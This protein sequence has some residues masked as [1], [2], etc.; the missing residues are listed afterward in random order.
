MRAFALFGT[1]A[2]LGITFGPTLSGWLLSVVGW[3]SI[4]L[5]HAVALLLVILF[6]SSIPD[7]KISQKKPFDFFGIALFISFLFLL[8]M[9]ITR[10]A[11]HGWSDEF[12]IY[13]SIFCILLLFIFIEKISKNPMLNFSLLFDFYF[14]AMISIP[15]V[16]SFSFVT[17]LTYF[18]TWLM[19]I[20]NFSP[21]FS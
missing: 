11:Q 9:T 8:M 15:V 5:V 2:G 13:F 10:V 6:S 20:K 4:F 16:T 21:F 19:Y 18:P 17:L 7:Q 1:T 12:T 14:L 3:R